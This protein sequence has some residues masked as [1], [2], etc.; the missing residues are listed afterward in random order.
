MRKLKFALAGNANVGKSALFNQLTGLHQHIANWPGKTVESAEG[1]LKY[2]DCEIEIV[3]LP[4]IY[5][6]STF[7][8]EELVSR[9]F[10]IKEKPDVV[11]N[12]IDS[13]ALERNLFFTLQLI[14]LGAPVV[15]ALNQADVA[16]QRG[17]R[18][19]EKKLEKLLGVPVVPTVATKGTGVKG[20]LER[21]IEVVN[22]KPLL[23]KFT[24]G[25]LESKLSALAIPLSK[26]KLP[27]SPRYAALKL[28]EG[29]EKIKKTIGKNRQLKKLTE[30]LEKNNGE[31]LYNAINQERY[32]IAARFAR[33]VTSSAP[34][35][36]SLKEKIDDL[37]THWFFGYLI[38]F[39]VL[40]AIFYSIFTFGSVVSTGIGNVFNQFRPP[41][42]FILGNLLWEGFVG[43]FV[44]GITLVIPYVLPFYFLLTILEDTGYI[45]RVAYL[46]DSLAHRVG[47]HGKA[48]IPL[49]LGYGCNVPACFACRIM[50]YDRDRLIT[51]FAITLVPCTARTV[52]ILTLV[53]AYLGPWWALGLYLFNILL[54]ALLA[55]VAFKILPGEPM[56]LIMEMPPYRMPSL[57]VVLSQ[58]WLKIK[59]IIT[60]VFPYYIIGGLALAV[61]QLLGIL[62][63]LNAI[64]TPITMGWL[65]LPSF[66]GTLLLFGIVRKEMVVVL[67]A[68]LFG[69]TDFTTLFTPLQMIVLTLVTMTYIPCLAMIHA[70]KR[71][72]G[73]RK[74]LFI[75]IFEIV[76]SI[77]LG[78]I[79]R[80]ALTPFF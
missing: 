23:K 8:S 76:F 72:F 73:W 56:G 74:A 63:I 11:V 9:E 78:G 70:L 37:T 38:M 28:L 20:L 10:I 6:L 19:D 31:P 25:R 51:A 69:T 57:K 67:P 61:L 75:T 21:C 54:V 59:S 46:L 48:I 50:E 36:I 18:I 34:I 22:K 77:V 30:K 7:S 17:L 60:I 68:L 42:S 27:F 66:V 15:I 39:L 14:E 65:G 24:Y 64:L 71:E 12:V 80:L 43:G 29:D 47:F 49:I 32:R 55:K 41:Q 58:T 52:V 62:E 5:S 79:V 26:L 16:K 44:A 33:K 4:G 2:K 13:S 45:T 40:G 1:L 35:Q 3:D 53:G